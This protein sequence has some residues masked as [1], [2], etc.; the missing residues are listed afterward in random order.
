MFVVY[1]RVV[2]L[3]KIPKVLITCGREY[4]HTSTVK[5]NVRINIWT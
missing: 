4:L 3:G 5:I 1:M 2:E